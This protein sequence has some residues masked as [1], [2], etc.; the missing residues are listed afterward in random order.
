MIL[1]VAIL[2]IK[3]EL[4]DRFEEAFKEESKI[5]SSMKGYITH[6][7]KA[8]LHHFY[9][10]LYGEYGNSEVTGIVTCDQGRPATV[11]DTG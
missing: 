1:E 2:H 9:E 8:L 4:A 10:L 5:I 3:R 6:E 7:R 11:L